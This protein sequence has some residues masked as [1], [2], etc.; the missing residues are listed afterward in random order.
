MWGCASL[1]FVS[2]L[3]L[4]VASALLSTVPWANTACTIVYVTVYSDV[5]FIII[6]VSRCRWNF[7][8]PNWLLQAIGDCITSAIKLHV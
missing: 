7:S 6:I 1:V 2:V 8:K 5:Y 3:E 4:N